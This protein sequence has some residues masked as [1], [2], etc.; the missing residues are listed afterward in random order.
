[1]GSHFFGDMGGGRY[2]VKLGVT[3]TEFLNIKYDINQTS[4]ENKENIN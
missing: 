4:D 2:S 1:M 3:K